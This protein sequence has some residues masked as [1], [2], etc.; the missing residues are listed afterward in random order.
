MNRNEDNYQSATFDFEALDACPF[1]DGAAM[2]PNGKI[3]WFG[4]DFWYVFCPACG[5][6]FMN[7]RPTRESY[8]DFYKNLFWQQKIRNAGFHKEG[9]MWQSG[10]YKWDDEKKWDPKEGLENRLEKHREQRAKTIIPVVASAISLGADSRVL[11]VGCGFGVT[12]SEFKK[13]YQCK[14]FAVEPSDEAQ[15]TIK[16]F[17]IELLGS[18]AEDLE[19]IGKR[20]E[21]FDAIVFSHSLEN[22]IDPVS[23]VR[24]AKECLLKSGIIYI[25]TPNL[26]VFDQMNPYHPYIF[27]HASLQF[28]AQRLGLTYKRVSEP[29]DKMLTVILNAKC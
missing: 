19:N 2:V 29:K 27:S 11:E 23:I 20:G 1:C 15:K 7:P 25:Q 4:V 21:K 5:L 26:L 28:L 12:L 9:Q 3:E 22:T 16:D 17:N 6:K 10:K 24:F 8:K 14:V 13:K 18:Y